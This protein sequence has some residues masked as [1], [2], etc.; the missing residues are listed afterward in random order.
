MT[1]RTS[2]PMSSFL[3]FDG[4]SRVVLHPEH[5]A[6]NGEKT[7]TVVG[8]LTFYVGDRA[9]N[10]WVNIPHGYR[11]TGA[12]VPRLFKFLLPAK[13]KHGRAA[14]IHHYLCATGKARIKKVRCKIERDVANEI[15][16]QAMQVSGVGF[17]RR[18]VLYLIACLYGGR[19]NMTEADLSLS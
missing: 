5:T 8:C 11:V 7:Y 2:N 9:A 12:D 6:R 15:F 10:Y 1:T 18:W 14:I 17:I 19:E 13:S 3:K 16:M 4:K